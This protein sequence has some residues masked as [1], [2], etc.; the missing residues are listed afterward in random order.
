MKWTNVRSAMPKHRQKCYAFTQMEKW[1]LACILHTAHS[2][3]RF[4]GLVSIGCRFRKSQNNSK[5]ERSG[6]DGKM[7]TTVF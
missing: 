3:M 1:E 6:G 7:H 5:Q 2:P 4:M